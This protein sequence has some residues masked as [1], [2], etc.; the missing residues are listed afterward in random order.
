ME[1]NEVKK[2][3]EL[4]IH[5]YNTRQAFLLITEIIY[6]ETDDKVTDIE[7]YWNWF[8]EKWKECE[9][10]VSQKDN[11]KCV[12]HGKTTDNYVNYYGFRIFRMVFNLY[13]KPMFNIIF[14]I[15]NYR[16]FV[17]KAKYKIVENREIVING[18]YPFRVI[19]LLRWD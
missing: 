19:D 8:K 14:N 10:I 6:N 7:T 15:S 11:W 1:L 16:K 5:D 2:W 13:V 18:E 9:E 12:R 4:N 3:A 17:F